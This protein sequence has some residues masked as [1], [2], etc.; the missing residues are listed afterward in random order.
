LHS[1]RYGWID[2]GQLASH[3]AAHR[4][5]AAIATVP[6]DA[7]FSSKKSAAIFKN[8]PEH[9]SLLFHGNDHLKNELA[10]FPSSQA[11]LNS[12]AQALNRIKSMERRTSLEV[13]RVMVPP[14]GSCSEETLNVMARLGFQAVSTTLSSLEKW[15][16]DK[17]WTKSLGLK[18]SDVV[19]GLPIVP[20]S[21]F[22]LDSFNSI[23]LAA[24][25]QRAMIPCGH[26]EDVA[27]GLDC[28]ERIAEVIH[29]LG[30]VQWMKM[31]DIARLNYQ[32]RR[33]N[34]VLRI[35]ACAR[36]LRI[37]IPAD[38]TAISIERPW[39]L[40]TEKEGIRICRDGHSDMTFRE[41]GGEVIAV[42]PS[43][44]LEIEM[45]YPEQIPQSMAKVA[46]GKAWAF[47][48]RLLCEGRDRLA[49][50][51]RFRN[52]RA[53]WKSTRLVHPNLP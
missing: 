49:P 15:N 47:T 26:H 10:S 41:Y 45:V 2:Y 17:L 18:M 51:R 46:K 25:M 30:Q 22:K 5:H 53:F 50:L 13:C 52:R 33:Q 4:Y 9:I 42:D 16:P 21:V 19:A 31:G 36:L 38:V 14:H 37:A 29:S 12:M 28:L 23:L 27:S 1:T 24:Y 43:S 20:R 6:L 39:L 35:K 3:A 48:R 40:Q 32:T 8:H 7:W 34:N 11:A 44:R